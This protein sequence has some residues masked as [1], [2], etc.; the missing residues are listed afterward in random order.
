[1]EI[2]SET[3]QNSS[4]KQNHT[5]CPLLLSQA[6]A[7]SLSC[8]S[9][10]C[11]FVH[12][13]FSL[14]IFN[15]SP[16]SRNLYTRSKLVYFKIQSVRSC[17]IVNPETATHATTHVSYSQQPSSSTRALQQPSEFPFHHSTEAALPRPLHPPY[18]PIQK[19]LWVCLLTLTIG[20]NLS[21]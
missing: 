4:R 5:L 7:S 12:E 17:S 20:F 9:L 21:F 1:M 16:C 3:R 10:V 8:T 13:Y 11:I 14:H 18:C 2:T 19:Q 6:F 15:L